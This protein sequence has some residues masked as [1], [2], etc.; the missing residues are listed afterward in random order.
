MVDVGQDQRIDATL[1]G[2]GAAE[3]HGHLWYMLF[4]ALY[5]IGPA[6]VAIAIMGWLK[7]F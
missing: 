7:T 2:S 5:L 3:R 4:L 6:L 1:G